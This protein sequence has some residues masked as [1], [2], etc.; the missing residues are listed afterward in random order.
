LPVLVAAPQLVADAKRINARAIDKI[1]ELIEEVPSRQAE[2]SPKT[3]ALLP[4]LP[5]PRLL[6]DAGI[7]PDHKTVLRV[8]NVPR[9][10]FERQVESDARAETRAGPTVIDNPHQ[11]E[12]CAFW[13]RNICLAWN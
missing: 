2:G 1:G 3:G 7:S 8:H 6:E 9:D 12:P 10:S 4:I 13:N 11:L 5:G